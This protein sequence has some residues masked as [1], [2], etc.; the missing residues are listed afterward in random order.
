[1]PQRN[2]RRATNDNGD[3][4][5]DNDMMEVG[6]THMGQGFVEDLTLTKGST[7]WLRAMVVEGKTFVVSIGDRQMSMADIMPKTRSC[8]TTP[9]LVSF[10]CQLLRAARTW[11]ETCKEGSIMI[12][13]VCAHTINLV[14]QT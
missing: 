10:N 8:S 12:M 3:A 13:S 1:M 4:T 5:V 2:V 7:S 11:H 6:D 9:I 14:V